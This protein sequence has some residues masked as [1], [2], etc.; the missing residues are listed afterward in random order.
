MP[1]QTWIYLSPDDFYCTED[2]FLGQ[3]SQYETGSVGAGRYSG[4][5]VII[6]VGRAQKRGAARGRH[7]LG[8]LFSPARASPW[9]MA[10]GL[11]PGPQCKMVRVFVCPVFQQK[12][13]IKLYLSR[14]ILYMSLNQHRKSS[15]C[16]LTCVARGVFSGFFLWEAGTD[17]NLSEWRWPLRHSA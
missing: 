16:I 1:L 8:G 10:K 7:G 4:Q 13:L 3:K 15:L 11:A 2:S 5:W 14:Q 12:L 17:G 6:T 9:A